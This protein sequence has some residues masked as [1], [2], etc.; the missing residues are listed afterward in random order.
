MLKR[1][2][3]STH[4][5]FLFVLLGGIT[6]ALCGYAL[7]A[8]QMFEKTIHAVDRQDLALSNAMSEIARHQLEQTLRLNEVLLNARI[9]NREKFEISNEGYIQSG[10]RLADNLLEGRNLSQKGIDQAETEQLLKALDAI[11]TGIKEIEKSH[12]DFEHLGSSLIRGIYQYEFL[13]R[14]S[15]LGSG[16]HLAAEE[17]ETQHLAFLKNTL[18][19][20]EDETRS[21]EGNI[22]DVVEKIKKL[23]QTLT[24]DATMRKKQAYKVLV[25]GLLTVLGLGLMFGL[26]IIKIH[27]D[28]EQK[29]YQAVEES[30]V[31]LIRA[32]NQMRNASRT[33][34]STGEKIQENIAKQG[35]VFAKGAEEMHDL[36]R[37]A[38]SNLHESALATTL[39]AEG[40]ASIEQT[41]LWIGQINQ[42]ADK[43]LSLG[44]AMARTVRALR[45]SVM[46]IN[47]QATNASAEA[48]RSEAS[49]SFV[50]YTDEIKSVSRQAL[51][52]SEK[53]SGLLETAVK[54]IQT[55]H[56]HARTTRRRF[57]DIMQ[58][59]DRTR[60]VM[61]NL[62]EAIRK[63]SGLVRTVQQSTS[64][65]QGS[66]D[67]NRFL[68]E[69]LSNARAT[70]RSQVSVARKTFGNWP[71]GSSATESAAPAGTTESDESEP[72]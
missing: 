21:M 59:I 64:A 56:E 5:L 44:E 34:D 12:A 63:Q 37:T 24:L 69:E 22:K 55:G 2:K 18:S 1:L 45:E 53:M 50:V 51:Q 15:Q 52:E 8:I 26:A 49:R 58:V 32:V 47:L 70:I 6:A 13:T 16:D 41:N 30:K 35:E 14:S 40:E 20:L 54:D 36:V 11:K 9:G 67:S 3:L 65:V 60:T 42:D 72:G 66:L 71:L 4:L 19:T 17:S 68:L 28:R 27:R 29:T 57:A 23:S 10:K 43:S 62:A 7:Y 46:Q 31:T 48:S 38:E 25:P 33:L 61:T 39:M